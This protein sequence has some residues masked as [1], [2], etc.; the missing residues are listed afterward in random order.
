M[1][2]RLWGQGKC[3][4]SCSRDN[5]QWL[6]E[7]W[8]GSYRQNSWV[9]L[10]EAGQ[11]LLRMAQKSL[12]SFEM[13]LSW[14]GIEVWKLGGSRSVIQE[15]HFVLGDKVKEPDS[16]C[17]WSPCRSLSCPL[18]FFS[19]REENTHSWNWTVWSLIMF[20]R[21]MLPLVIIFHHS[22]C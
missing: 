16:K 9:C 10:W 20:S 17:H 22:L 12:Q 7:G 4:S 6:S 14:F 2:C 18:D 3:R 1:R 15:E 5:L 8:E 13:F 19:L 11:R 21:G